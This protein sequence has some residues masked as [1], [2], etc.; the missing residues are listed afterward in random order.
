MDKAA[1]E[2]VHLK[3]TIAVHKSTSSIPLKRLWPMSKSVH[4]GAGPPL[5][6]WGL[7]I[8]PR[9]SKG[10][11]RSTLWCPKGP[12]AEIVIDIPLNSCNL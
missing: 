12:E 2:E 10:K 5:R 8:S 9:W 1:P 6:D 3:V 11:R 4:T 7:W